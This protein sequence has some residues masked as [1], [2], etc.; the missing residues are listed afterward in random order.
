MNGLEILNTVTQMPDRSAGLIGAYVIFAICLCAL[1]GM[2]VWA[3]KEM[4]EDTYLDAMGILGICILGLVFIG[5]CV[6]N[7]FLIK[8][9]VSESSTR[10]TI[11]YATIDDTVPWSEVNEKYEL[12]QQDGKIYQLRLR[13]DGEN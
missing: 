1:A 3:I 5:C 2:V 13:K 8:G 7:Y 12:I 6:G 9:V 11:V 4:M 10:E